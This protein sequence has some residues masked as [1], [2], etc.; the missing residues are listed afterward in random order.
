[1][2]P[3][4]F[5]LLYT[6]SVSIVIPRSLPPCPPLSQFRIIRAHPFFM[7]ESRF[8]ELFFLFSL[9]F[10]GATRRCSFHGY[11]VV[12]PILL[13]QVSTLLVECGEPFTVPFCNPSF[14][15]PR[16]AFPLGVGT[17]FIGQFLLLIVLF[18]VFSFSSV[19]LGDLPLSDSWREASSFSLP[20]F[21]PR[22]AHGRDTRFSP[23][24]FSGAVPLF[25]LGP[26]GQSFPSPPFKAGGSSPFLRTSDLPK[27][28]YFFL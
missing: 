5:R 3:V 9:L 17:G 2:R 12:C 4:V 13:H 18:K 19:F 1:L 10:L 16:P 21:F 25:L 6:F 14:S 28:F 8:L 22:R 11:T 20:L 23:S 7:M 26:T 24:S 27:S 15:G